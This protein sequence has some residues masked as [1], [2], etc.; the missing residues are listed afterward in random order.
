MLQRIFKSTA[1][2]ALA[3]LLFSAVLSSFS[4]PTGGDMFEVYINKKL[5]IRQFVHLKEPVKTLQLDPASYNDEIEVYY[6]HCGQTGTSRSITLRDAQNKTLKEWR[7]QDAPGSKTPMACNLKEVTGWQRLSNGS[8]LQLYY[9]SR[10]LPEGKMLAAF[11]TGAA[12]KAT[13]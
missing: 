11:T 10:E 5:A 13:R 4:A 3:L 12:A 7:F 8:T 2:A 1:F 9:A 6:S